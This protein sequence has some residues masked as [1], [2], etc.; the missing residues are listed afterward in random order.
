MSRHLLLLPVSLAFAW[1]A[2]QAAPSAADM[3]IS[4]SEQP[5]RLI[6]DTSLYRAGKGVVLRPQD[7][8]ESD[9]GALQVDTGGASLVLG[10]ATKLFISGARELVLL[11]GWMKL[12]CASGRAMQLV[13]AALELVC[14]GATVTMHADEGTTEL[15]TEAGTVSIQERGEGARRPPVKLAV[16]QFAARSGRQPLRTVDRPS[17]AFI[18]A[19]PPG[20]SDELAA[21]APGKP[22]LPRRE[23]A[24]TYAELASWVSAQPRLRQQLRRRF[25]PVAPAR[26]RPA[27]HP[28]YPH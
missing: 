9:G 2:A 16:E 8:L 11:D 10:P 23:R 17:S 26:A 27:A 12:R 25:E 22:A 3:A 20:F 5:A 14:E 21:L 15:F 19:L 28:V 7:M 1:P 4:F 13:T 24:V 6:R 18:A